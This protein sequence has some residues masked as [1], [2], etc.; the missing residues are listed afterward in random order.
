MFSGCSRRAVDGVWPSMILW[1]IPLVGQVWFAG[2]MGLLDDAIREHL[3]LRR[4]RGA[5]PGEVAQAEKDALGPVS[6]EG[7]GELEAPDELARG[8][9]DQRESLL[10]QPDPT[11]AVDASTTG[12]INQETVEINMD[13]ELAA[14][15]DFEPGGE[16]ADG[17]DTA[18]AARS[19][20]TQAN[21]GESLEWEMPGD[22][23]AD[24]EASAEEPVEDVLEETPDFLR[25]T[26]R[27]ST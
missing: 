25:D 17:G 21:P 6:R 11:S 1:A 19:T 16:S 3:E 9:S 22:M 2:A 24:E 27:K 14:E 10:G 15:V 13:A 18:A 23:G 5:D 4:L 26:D 7:A 8:P 12:D 20:Y